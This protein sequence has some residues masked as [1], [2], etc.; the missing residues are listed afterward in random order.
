[1][2]SAQPPVIK[3]T[4]LRGSIVVLTLKIADAHALRPFLTYALVP[5]TARGL[6]HNPADRAARSN[7]RDSLTLAYASYDG[8][9]SSGRCRQAAMASMSPAPIR[10]G[11]RAKSTQT[12]VWSTRPS[13]TIRRHSASFDPI[14]AGDRDVT[15]ALAEHAELSVQMVTHDPNRTLNFVRATRPR[16]MPAQRLGMTRQNSWPDRKRGRSTG[17]GTSIEERV[18]KGRLWE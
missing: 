11:P 10:A 4:V 7:P 1:M 17:A 9:K 5:P 13:S 15:Q 18:S 6:R 14:V 12:S 16:D 3:V 2:F 8:S